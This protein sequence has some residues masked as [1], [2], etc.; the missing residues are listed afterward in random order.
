MHKTDGKLF[1][2]TAPI[3]GAGAGEGQCVGGGG[4]RDGKQHGVNRILPITR[5]EQLGNGK[6]ETKEKEMLSHKTEDI[7]SK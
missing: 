3:P 1:W 2:V 6:T 7:W 4:P 5:M